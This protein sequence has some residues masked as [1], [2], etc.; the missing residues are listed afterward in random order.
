MKVTNARR[1]LRMSSLSAA[2]LVATS[3]SAVAQNQPEAERPTSTLEKIEV[4]GSRIKRVDM[5]TASP[6]TVIDRQAIRATG[7]V[8]VGEFLQRT[9]A[10]SGAATNPQV[11][12]GGGENVPGGAGGA[13]ADIRGLGA[14]RTLVLVE[15][16]RWIGSFGVG[17]G[18]V[19]INTIPITM[20]ERVEVLKDGASAIYGSDAIGGVVNFILRKDFNG[21]EASALAGFSSRG[22]ADTRQFEVMGGASN[23]RG[24][25]IFGATYHEEKE[26]RAADREYSAEPYLL[27][28]G[29]EG[30]GGTSRILTGRYVVPRSLA[31]A[32]GISCP[33]TTATVALTRR[34]GA[35]GSGWG[36]FRCFD[37]ANDNYNFQADGNLTLTP[38]ERTSVFGKGEYSL[39]D[40]VDAFFLAAWTNTR[41]S[42]RL[43]PL[44]FDG[45]DSVDDVPLSR[46]SIYNPF[47][48]DIADARLRLKD[49]IPTRS[50]SFDTDSYQFTGG[51]RGYFGSSSW[52][53]DASMSYGRISQDYQTQGYLYRPGLLDATGPSMYDPATGT[54]ICVREANNAATR[55]DGCVPINLFGPAPD[56]STAEGRRQLA[57]LAGLNPTLFFHNENEMKVYSANASGDLFDLPA[58]KVGLAVGIERREE[59]ALSRADYLAIIPEGETV[60]KVAQDACVYG[61]TNGGFSLNEVYAE[62]LVPIL[63]EVPF[64]E[65][66]NITFGTRYSDYSN[67]GGTTNSKVGFEWKPYSDLLV[68]GTYAQVFRAPGI[69]DMFAPTI[70]SAS[71]YLDP[72]NGYRGGGDPR[73]CIGVPTDGSFRQSNTQTT[74]FYAAN[75]D[76]GPEEGDVMTFGFAFSPPWVNGLSIT[77][78]YWRVG[79]SNFIVNI[80][81]TVMLNQCF[82]YGRF[83]D[84]FERDASGDV[85]QMENVIGNFGRLDTDGFDLSIRHAFDEQSW[86]RLAWNLDATYLARYDVELLE[87]DPTTRLGAF[88]DIPESVGLAGTF[89]DDANGGFGN[90]ARWRALNNLTWSFDTW[91][92][93]LSTRYIHHVYESP[94]D[95]GDPADPGYVA[96]R[97]VPSYTQSDLTVGYRLP[98]ASHDVQVGVRN[99]T[100]RQPPRVY[101][102]FN[103]TTDLRTYDAI[104]RYFWMKYTARF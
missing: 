17:N 51:L 87:G 27:A 62:A 75:P 78:D 13:T 32:N 89:V 49:Y 65:K 103:A 86:G 100:D 39:T 25:V 35:S 38:Q 33:G 52:S 74:S 23:E 90:L 21:V 85:A 91:N 68:R 70:P 77:V 42:Y 50:T 83:C 66:L 22:D 59:S 14:V 60:C 95:Q 104:G 73:A 9:P 102:G 54:P 63:S 5:E 84:T 29:E 15:G 45:R 37:P 57:A 7:A 58:G 80:P 97:R 44:P 2:I 20:I 56:A 16:R 11:N 30:I 92:V 31:Q 6:V 82:N 43:A 40:S 72:C 1:S 18:A 99:L 46:H 81:E 94:A 48:V 34:D 8:T 55:I 10:I 96:K 64:A 28:N 61:V 53:W 93:S 47:G 12:N 71:T 67:F 98:G 101:S 76:L 36:D 88:P 4:T 41:A 24:N 26:V 79:I 69:G 3:A 19:D